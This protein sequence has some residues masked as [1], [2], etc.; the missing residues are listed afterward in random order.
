MKLIRLTSDS[1]D[2]RFDNSF[3]DEIIIEPKSKIALQSLAV[4]SDIGSLTIDDDNHDI[5][6]EVKTGNTRTVTLDNF[7]YDE[8]DNHKF[9]NDLQLKFNQGLQYTDGQSATKF[10]NELGFQF[11]VSVADAG[12]AEIQMANTRYAY[13]SPADIKEVFAIN[14]GVNVNLAGTNPVLIASSTTGAN[15]GR[16]DEKHTMYSVKPFT[17][18]CGVFRFRYSTYTASTE[19][20]VLSGFEF[21]LCDSKP[22]TWTLPSMPDSKKT[23]ALRGFQPTANYSVKKG[24]DADFAL[25]TNQDG[26]NVKPSVD[27]GG[28]VIVDATADILEMSIQ[29]ANIVC[30]VF[31]SDETVGNIL[32]TEPYEVDANGVPV[33]LFG[34][35]T[36]HGSRGNIEVTDMKFTPDAYL[37][38][39]P[40]AL[41]DPVETFGSG[42]RPTNATAN[43]TIKKIDFGSESVAS[44]LG[45]NNIINISTAGQNKIF[46][47]N[48]LFTALIENECYIILLENIQ[49]ESYDGLKQ[50]RKSILASI[51]NPTNGDRVIYEPN[52]NN[53]VELNN[54]NPI[55][56]RNIRARIFYQDYTPVKTLGLSVLSLLVANQTE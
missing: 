36:F 39:R 43:S 22:D 38:P 7:T 29:G 28:N 12:Q 15:S 21:G 9:L 52:T 46:I 6:F 55:S 50:G 31:K 24:D 30:T 34:Y 32:F 51:P 20:Q 1:N 40:T 37:E 4:R 18:G 3:N 19:S 54:A 44:F 13:S 56:L 48:N 11:K 23:Y 17:T 35:L 25:A 33:P 16:A 42:A 26:D 5:Q 45:F 49:L 10:K 14:E 47:G 27:G 8:N 41:S 53:Y 2:G